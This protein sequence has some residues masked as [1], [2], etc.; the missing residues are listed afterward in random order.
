MG[1]LAVHLWVLTFTQFSDENNI[2][3]WKGAVAGEENT[4]SC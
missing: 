1:V 4:G 2:F 3:P